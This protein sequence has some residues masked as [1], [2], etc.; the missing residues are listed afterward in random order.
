MKKIALILLISLMVTCGLQQ[1]PRID[2]EPDSVCDYKVAVIWRASYRTD[3]DFNYSVSQ[4]MNW[5]RNHDYKIMELCYEYGKDMTR[6]DV[7][8]SAVIK[9]KEI[10]N[11]M[12]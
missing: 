2:R 3:E 4:Q 7:L 12:E 8:K 11:E 6:K 1:T 9:Y 10:K 5:L